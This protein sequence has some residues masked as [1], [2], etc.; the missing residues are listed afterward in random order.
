MSPTYVWNPGGATTSSISVSP[1]V[2]TIYTVTI[3][4]MIPGTSTPTVISNTSTVTVLS[5][6]S[7]TLSSNSLICPG[8]TINLTASPGFTNY[9]WTGPPAY[10]STTTIASVSIPSATT[11]MVGTYT[12]TGKSSQGCSVKATTTVGLIPTSSI[13][14]TPSYTIC[15][16]GT[17]T[18]SL[19]NAIGATSYPFILLNGP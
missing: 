1:S 16:G 8:S 4:G 10:S 13:T 15:Q 2:T 12:V 19:T 7:L 14:T 11:S 9:V 3:S 18:F 5:V 17:Q 6:P